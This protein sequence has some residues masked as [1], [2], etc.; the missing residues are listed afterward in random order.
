MGYMA[1]TIEVSDAFVNSV[2]KGVGYPVIT[3][4]QIEFIYSKE[5]II[6]LIIEP[7]LETFYTYFPM[8]TDVTINSSGGSLILHNAPENMLGIIHTSFVPNSSAGSGSKMQ[9][10][11]F[12]QNP[13]FSASQVVSVGGTYSSY[14]TPFDYGNSLNIYQRKFYQKSM[15]SQNTV[16]TATFDER[17]NML[18]CK[19]SISG[20]FVIKCGCYDPIVANIPKRLQKHFV[21]YCKGTLMKEFSNIVNLA[22]MDLPLEI[23]ADDLSDKGGDIVEAELEYFTENSTCTVMR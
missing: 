17:E 22:N 23:N 7:C 20:V 12:Y 13:F 5:Q 11:Q 18:K 9:S 2:L 15:E 4:E 3:L 6:Q 14:G 1:D 10:G 21:T 8:V 19:S 16:Y